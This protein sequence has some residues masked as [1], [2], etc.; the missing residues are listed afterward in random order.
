MISERTYCVYAHVFPNGKKYVGIT[1]KRPNYRWRGGNGYP[2]NIIMTRAIEKYGWENVKH[3][4]VMDGVFSDVA[5][6]A[7]K[8]LI[9]R[10]NLRDIRYGYN[11]RDG[12][13]SGNTHTDISKEKNR[14]KHT[15]KKWTE[16][17]RKKF[18]NSQIGKVPSQA[19]HIGASIKNAKS[20]EITFPD[21]TVKTYRT[22]TDAAADIGRDLS[23][24]ARKCR[25][26]TTTKSGYSFRYS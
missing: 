12:G 17:Q 10:L 18:I 15:G 7:E 24:T 25:N 14:I 6:R 8:E 11:L 23:D 1:C 21:G 3:I 26:K 19:T 16:E 13:L 5:E 20:A 4:I 22:V 2:S 9:K